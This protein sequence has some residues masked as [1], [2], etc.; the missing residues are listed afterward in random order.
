[1]ADSIRTHGIIQPI[2]VRP[3][4]PHEQDR[5]AIV[6]NGEKAFRQYVIIA[7]NP[8]YHGAI[9]AGLIELPCVIRVTDADPAYVL[10]LVENLQRRDLSGRERAQA[11]RK[12]RARQN[13]TGFSPVLSL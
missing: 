10:N 2:V 3:I 1:M 7:G 8:R 6:I 12:R 13:A 5:Y 4:Q 9:Q 11:A